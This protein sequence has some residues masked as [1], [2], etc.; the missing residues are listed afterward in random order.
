MKN[1]S[2]IWLLKQVKNR[3]PA[4]TVM[5]LA[6]VG[7]ALLT[8]LFA[9]GS[10]GV[11]DSAV[12]GDPQ[13]FYGACMKQAGIIAGI[14]LCLALLRHLQERLR[15]DLERDW[16]QRLLHGLLH[17]EYR[18]VSAYHSAELL[19]RMNADVNKV[20]D[21]ILTIVPSAAA[22]VTKLVAAVVVL[23]VLDARFAMVIVALGA[24]AILATALMRRKLKNLNKQVSEH[25]GKVSALLQ[26]AMEKLLMV[27]AMDVSGE[28]EHRADIL[29]DDRYAIQRK[30][31]N[32]SLSLFLK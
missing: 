6:Q 11:I 13:R 24:A 31:K 29:L 23:G 18:A 32:V 25:D 20:N 9:L 22:M 16:K 3:I 4:I 5:T 17:G 21:G 14:L 7:H 10:R 26:E 27:Q 15:A 8:V 2:L 19:N 28:V 12:A 30:R 1:H